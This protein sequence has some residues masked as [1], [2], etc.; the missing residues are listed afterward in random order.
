VKPSVGR[1]D[2]LG[3]E[4]VLGNPAGAPVG[5][6]L[7]RV[8]VEMHRH[9]VNVGQRGERNRV[10]PTR[11]RLAESRAETGRPVLLRERPI[12]LIPAEEAFVAR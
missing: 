3:R 1:A 12:D 9:E 8:W 4:C 10:E 11:A 5:R 6:G 7:P 2:R